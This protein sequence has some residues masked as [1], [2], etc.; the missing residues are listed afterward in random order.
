LM[1]PLPDRKG[2]L[3][4]EIIEKN[5]RPIN[6]HA[7]RTAIIALENTHNRAGGTIYPLE[8]IVEIATVARR[9][10]LWMHL[11]GARIW[12][13][14]V[15]T[16]IALA[17]YAS[18]FDSVTACLSK[19]L[20]A[21]VGSM[22]MG[23]KEFI[24]KARRTR[25]MFGGGMRQAGILAAAGIYAIENN[26]ARLEED[27]ANARF[28]AEHLN[29]MPGL[30][31]DLETVQ[32]NIVIAGVDPAAM[33]AEEFSKRLAAEGVLCVPFGAGRVRFVPNL[34]TTHKD[35]REAL[36]AVRRVVEG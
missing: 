4:A 31:V 5:I 21:P 17:T 1:H 30:T 8:T 23:T 6:I 12:N 27:H 35:C 9:H 19:A 3:S 7:P 34:D 20:G 11:D 15:A 26:V 2:V 14:H 13:A 32:T 18:Y 28:L 29:T 10:H 16:G 22:I 25:K 24:L 36:D 33:T